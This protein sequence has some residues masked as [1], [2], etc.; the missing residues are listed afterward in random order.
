MQGVWALLAA[1]MLGLAAG[2]GAFTFVYADGASYLRDDA[3]ACGNCHV[4]QEHLTA[5]QRGSHSGAAVCNDCHAPHGSFVAKYVV[6]GINGFNHGLAFTTGDFPEVFAMTGLNRRVTERACRA[7]HDPV[8]SAIDGG[9]AG[10]D[11]A[12]E[13]IRCH[14]EVGHP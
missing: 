10:A 8:V 3:A 11:G 1:V 7:C 14:R 2:A 12:V 4:M 9:H 6:K 13:C 5:W